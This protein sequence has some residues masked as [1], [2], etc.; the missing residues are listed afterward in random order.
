MN[1]LIACDEIF[2]QQHAIVHRL[3]LPR[4]YVRINSFRAFRDR[5]FVSFFREI[6]GTRIHRIGRKEILKRGILFFPRNSIPDCLATGSR[7]HTNS[8]W[9]VRVSISAKHW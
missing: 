3:A 2:M 9:S 7:G 4:H 5:F 1:S 8:D 6:N